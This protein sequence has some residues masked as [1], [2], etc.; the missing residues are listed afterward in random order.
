MNIKII[1]NEIKMPVVS[2]D[3]QQCAGDLEMHSKKRK[4]KTTRT[5]K[6]QHE[7]SA[8]DGLCTQMTQDHQWTRHGTNMRAQY[9]NE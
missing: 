3:F 6:G 2:A 8:G 9:M 1:I 7:V 4:R 5:G